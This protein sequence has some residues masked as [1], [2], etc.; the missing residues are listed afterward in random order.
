MG[1]PIIDLTGKT[2]GDWTVLGLSHR[3]ES[4]AI[5]WLC[6]CA[7]GAEMPVLSY[8]L[9]HGRSGCC[10]PC[11]DRKRRRELV[12]QRFNRWTV[13]ADLGRPRGTSDRRFLCRCDCGNEREVVRQDLVSGLSTQCVTCGHRYR[14]ITTKE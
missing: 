5:Y 8:T 2:F 11:T 9:R 14:K 4:R 7:C 1:R 12:G 6:R 13:L 10:R 3:T